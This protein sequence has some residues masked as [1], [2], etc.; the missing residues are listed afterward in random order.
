MPPVV[1]PVPETTQKSMADRLSTEKGRKALA[2]ELV[3]AGY[4]EEVAQKMLD[5]L[6]GAKQESP[7]VKAL[8]DKLAA[9]ETT[10]AENKTTL[11]DVTKRLD[12]LESSGP[13]SSQTPDADLEREKAE[14]AAGEKD[15]YEGTLLDDRNFRR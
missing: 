2:T 7:R 9:T 3:E 12:A 13:P 10:L 14:K 8:Q 5:D 4:E 6:A 15:I 1:E 11:A